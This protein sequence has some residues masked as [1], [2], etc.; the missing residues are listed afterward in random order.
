MRLGNRLDLIDDDLLE[1]RLEFGVGQL[2]MGPGHE[3]A[4]VE[5]VQQLVDAVEAV[6]GGEFP[7][8]DAADV[9]APQGPRP[10]GV[11]EHRFAQGIGP[12]RRGKI[13][14]RPGWGRSGSAPRPPRL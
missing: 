14:L 1:D 9:G 2:V 10:R 3:A 8:Q 12:P 4:V 7:L 13:G 6:A 5:A 11:A